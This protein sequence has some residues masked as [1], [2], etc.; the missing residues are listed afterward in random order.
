MMLHDI[1]DER[2]VV[3]SMQGIHEKFQL[4]VDIMK[5]N[6]L[7]SAIPTKWCNLKQNYPLEMFKW[8]EN[9]NVKVN[10]KPK[11]LV[12]VKCRDFYWEFVNKKHSEPTYIAKWKMLYEHISF[13]LKQYISLPL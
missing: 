4:Q 11:E 6:S 5:Y 8:F 12:K 3:L 1:L 13:D 7:L 9:I 10:Q 2:G